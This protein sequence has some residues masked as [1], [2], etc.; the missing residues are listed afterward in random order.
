MPTGSCWCGCGNPTTRRSF[1]LAIHDRK[2]E[3]RLIRMRYG[4]IAGLRAAHGYTP[5]GKNLQ[6]DFERWRQAAERVGALTT[7]ATAAGG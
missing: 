5:S 3:S 7:P 1:F 4:G 2:A 6:K